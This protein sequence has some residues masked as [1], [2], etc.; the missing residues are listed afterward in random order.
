VSATPSRAGF[1]GNSINNRVKSVFLLTDTRNPDGIKSGLD[2][3]CTEK[4]EPLLVRGFAMF[5]F[6]LP[7]V[8]FV[9]EP[10]WKPAGREKWKGAA[11]QPEP[12]KFKVLVVDDEHLVADTITKILEL[13]DFRAIAA[14]GGRSA[15]E[16]AK[17]IEPDYLLTD[18][19][20]PEMNGVE[21]AIAIRNLLPKTR[22]LLFSGHAGVS[23]II[24]Q[25]G[26]QGHEFELV[27]KPIHPEKLIEILRKR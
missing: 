10:L 22:I 14:Y 9:D 17:K 5:G 12:Q 24:M 1:F 21:L 19:R 4:R 23:D 11:E 27:S 7:V 8:R 15:L 26:Q 2:V 13:Y 25:A 6:G 20:M 16:L 18:V 3:S